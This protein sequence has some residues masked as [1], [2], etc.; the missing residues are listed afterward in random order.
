VCEFKPIYFHWRK[1]WVVVEEKV[2]A[3]EVVADSVEEGSIVGDSFVIKRICKRK[4]DMN[5]RN[6]VEQKKPWKAKRDDVLSLWRNIR[7][8]LPIDA[9]TVPEEREGTRYRFD[10]IRITG[11]SSFINAI[12]SRMK[13]FLRY[14]A[15]PGV[16]LDVE[17]HKIET[18][19]GVLQSEPRFVCYIHLMED[20]PKP[21][22]K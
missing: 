3:A 2:A 20:K 8:Y 18:K 16:K 17:Y 11:R 13:E 6:F 9:E 15:Q 21:K 1:K 12:L 10:G 4:N 7:P 22:I 14:D 19:E 5:F